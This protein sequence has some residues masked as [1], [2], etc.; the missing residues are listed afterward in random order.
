MINAL[1]TQLPQFKRNDTRVAVLAPATK[2]LAPWQ[3][4]ASASFAIGGGVM[5]PGIPQAL[6]AKGFII[7][8]EP[9]WSN[10][11]GLRKLAELL[12]QKEVG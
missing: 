12:L 1:F 9:A 6:A 2:F 8:S 5:L 3:A 10:A 11:R 4:S 7:A